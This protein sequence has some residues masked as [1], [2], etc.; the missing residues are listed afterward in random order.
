MNTPSTTR[1]ASA[2]HKRSPSQ[3][4]LLRRPASSRSPRSALLRPAVLL[5]LAAVFIVALTFLPMSRLLPSPR[6]GSDGPQV[7]FP[8]LPSTDTDRVRIGTW[9]L[10]FDG[11]RGQTVPVGQPGDGSERPK[12]ELDG[13][14]FGERVRL[15]PAPRALYGWSAGADCLSLLLCLARQPWAERRWR[16]LDTILQQRYDIIGCVRLDR[17]ALPCMLPAP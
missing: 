3:A 14:G 10:R 16:V 17:L 12:H 1:T 4:P 8:P 7:P 6:R 9:N 2:V 13:D 11:L 5:P 15:G